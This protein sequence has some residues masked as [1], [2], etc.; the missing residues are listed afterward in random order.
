MTLSRW[1][2]KVSRFCRWLRTNLISAFLQIHPREKWKKCYQI[3]CC[4][5]IPSSQPFRNSCIIAKVK[6]EICGLPFI[7]MTVVAILSVPFSQWRRGG[8]GFIYPFK[9]LWHTFR[10]HSRYLHL[11]SSRATVTSKSNSL[12]AL[13]LHFLSPSRSSSNF[14]SNYINPRLRTAK[15]SIQINMEH[16]E[17]RTRVGNCRARLEPAP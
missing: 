17:T 8:I 13:Y 7:G 15:Q 5:Q 14:G 6:T 9:S 1:A 3:E 10:F 2:Q 12:I 16:Q 4:C 11:Q